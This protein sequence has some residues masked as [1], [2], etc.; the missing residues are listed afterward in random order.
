MCEAIVKNAVRAGVVLMC[1]ALGVAAVD[2]IAVSYHSKSTDPLGLHGGAI[3]RHIVRD[4][5][6]EHDSTIYAPKDAR[7]VC[8]SPD[9]SRVAFVRMSEGSLCIMNIKGGTVVALTSVSPNA[10]IDW[11]RNEYIY[12][13]QIYNH[14]TLKRIDLNGGDIETVGWFPVGAIGLATAADAESLR[15]VALLDYGGGRYEV[16]TFDYRVFLIQSQAGCGGHI[17]PDG[18]Y[19]TVGAC[20]HDTAYHRLLAIEPWGGGAGAGL[21]A[22][23]G[24]YFN[25]GS[26]SV[27]S[28][29]WLVMS[30]GK[31]PELLQYHDMVL[32]ARDMSAAIRVTHND[33]GSYDEACD[34]WVGDPD[35]ALAKAVSQPSA[36]T[37]LR[38]SVAALRKGGELNIYAA[39]GTFMGR[40][41]GHDA[42]RR[43]AP[44]VY[45]VR[46]CGGQ[47]R[48][49]MRLVIGRE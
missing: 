19:Y 8:Q 24:E 11:T 7:S 18:A 5:T 2:G 37:F 44:G 45:L 33:S 39:D 40:V 12:F 41:S 3:V 32:M 34:F 28:A 14:V 36:T 20:E 22:P 35:N 30:V 43:V 38:E 13:T 49:T 42:L 9:G 10:V 46:P 17:S 6:V 23:Q 25:R 31:G 29:D 15:G 16:S 26:W 1:C 4:G 48:E 21:R 47:R 27:N